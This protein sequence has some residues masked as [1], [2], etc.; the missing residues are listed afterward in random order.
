MSEADAA[1]Y[2]SELAE[3]VSQKKSQLSELDADTLYKYFNKAYDDVS[4]RDPKDPKRAKRRAFMKK[5]A[6][7]HNDKKGW[8]RPQGV[9]KSAADAGKSA[10]GLARHLAKK[11]MRKDKD[12]D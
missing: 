9:K 11:D 10:A 1:K 6:A 8:K 4:D 12:E 7:Q 2:K 3:R 5:A